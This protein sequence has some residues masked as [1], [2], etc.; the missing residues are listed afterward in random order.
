MKRIFLILITVL[1]TFVL[2]ACNQSKVDPL[3]EDGDLGLAQL[4]SYEELV[5]LIGQSRPTGEKWSFDGLFRSDSVNMVPEAGMDDQLESDGESSSTSHSK[6]NVQ[7]EGVDEGDIIKTD[8]Q[9]I[10]RIKYNELQVVKLLGNGLME[11]ELVSSMESLNE[12][13]NYTYYSDLYLTD[14]YLVVIGQ[15]YQYFSMFRT[16]EMVETDDA[17][18]IMP[19]WY[20]YGTP[21]TLIT[22]YDLEDLSFV[23]EIEI[24][25]NLMTTRLIDDQLY[26][27]SN[28]YIYLNDDNIDPRPLFRQGDDVVVPEYSEIKYLPN[29]NPESFTIITHINLEDEVTFDYDIFLGASSWGQIYVSLNA[30]YLAST[31][32]NYHPLTRSYTLKGHL[33]S[34]M[35]TESGTVVYGGAGAFNGQV[36]NQFAMDEYNDTFRMVTT[37]GWGDTVVN[38]LYIFEREIVEGKRVLTVRA[39]LDQG[40]GLPRETVRSVRF[41]KDIVTVVTFEMIDPFYTIDLSDINNPII[42]GEL[43]VS[44][45]STYQH[46]WGEHYVLGIGYEASNDGM[47][48]GL[49]LALY[50]ISNIDE[51]VEVGKP[52]V[53]LNE[54]NGWSYSEA[55]HNHK[56]ILVA[57]ELGFIGFAMSRYHY[58]RN[59]YHYTSDYL[60]FEIDPTEEYPVSIAASISHIDFFINDESFYRQ[61]YR[62]SY[63]F[64]VERAVYV[65]DYLYVVSGEAITSHDMNN[66]FDRVK[67]LKFLLTNQ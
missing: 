49:K 51:P 2:F 23:D 56:A 58:F 10:Y 63:D 1:S 3:L 30:I 38:R 13:M 61:A 17:V 40:I 35:F 14:Q 9:R 53:L 33:V 52:L 19:S 45:F 37:E 20:W 28:Q 24:N 59:N 12:G 29:V 27:I 60:I 6:T 55:L 62:Y 42:R 21:Q 54:N 36:I 15:R 11:I 67:A 5:E 66:G 34:Y 26:V 8:G 46:P 22:I 7:V 25:G 64:S 32:W 47:I 16:G 50:D 65:G 44:G 4:R 31:Q 41:N 57:E 48:T 39:L 18:G 43:K